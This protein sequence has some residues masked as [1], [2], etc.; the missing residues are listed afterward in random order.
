MISEFVGQYK[1]LSNHA[2]VIIKLG[3]HIYPSVEHAFMSAKCDDPEWKT[4]C[5]DANNTSGD[6]KK[7]SRYVKLIDNWGK[8][9]MDVMF[10]CLEQ[11]FYQEPFKS[12]LTATGLENIQEGN[13]H[14]DV[15]WGVDLKVNPNVGENHLGRMIMTIRNKFTY[16]TNGFYEGDNLEISK[17]DK[18]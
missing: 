12:K 5:M 13:F 15:F 2:P 9:K 8:V 7:K 18:N 10:I 4:Y 11:K 17:R 14:D 1:W 16:V 3:E 6:V